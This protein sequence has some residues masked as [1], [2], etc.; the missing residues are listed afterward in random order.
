VIGLAKVISELF[1][2]IFPI[3]MVIG[4]YL[5]AWV[6]TLGLGHYL[7]YVVMAL[8]FTM[9]LWAGGVVSSNYV[10]NIVTYAVIYAVTS[11]IASLAVTVPISEV[12]RIKRIVLE[13]L[14]HVHSCPCYHH[15]DPLVFPLVKRL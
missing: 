6:K 4:Y 10:I 9:S 2:V 12:L 5:K 14:K 3:T 7:Q 1:L 13:P 8:V 15:V 11:M